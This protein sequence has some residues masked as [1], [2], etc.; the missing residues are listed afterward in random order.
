MSSTSELVFL[1]YRPRLVRRIALLSLGAVAG[2][3]LVASPRTYEYGKI[4][5]REMVFALGLLGIAGALRGMVISGLEILR[6]AV[7]VRI[8]DDRL[9][10]MTGGRTRRD[11]ESVRWTRV[12]SMQQQPRQSQTL[13]VLETMDDDDFAIDLTVLRP[14]D[15]SRLLVEVDRRISKR[16]RGGD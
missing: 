10:D 6:G 16:H 5:S 13:L 1:K 2:A 8:T 15:A 7:G 9:Y 12:I 3:L 4:L 11:V 14:E